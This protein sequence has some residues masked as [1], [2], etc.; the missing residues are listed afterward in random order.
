MIDDYETKNKIRFIGFGRVFSGVL[1]RGQKIF[2]IGP[3]PQKTQ[4]SPEKSVSLN[5]D[6]IQ[7]QEVVLNNLYILMAQ[8]LEG[9][10]EV[11]FI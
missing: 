8:Y 10:K 2:V 1:R 11:Y 4:H 6:N 5:K 9:V 7:I 3:K